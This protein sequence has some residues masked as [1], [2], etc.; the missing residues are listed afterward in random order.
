METGLL[1]D[2]INA[3][4][5]EPV[6]A[7]PISQHMAHRPPFHSVSIE[8][9]IYPDHPEFQILITR[10]VKVSFFKSP[11]NLLSFNLYQFLHPAK[12]K[13]FSLSTPLMLVT[14]LYA[15]I[16]SPLSSLYSIENIPSLFSLSSW[17]KHSI[18]VTS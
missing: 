14:I 2:H 16:W 12:Q 5:Q 4:H 3:G 9:N 17:L 15:S 18:S 13:R 8:P 7:I 1:A 10:M 6:Y 11:V